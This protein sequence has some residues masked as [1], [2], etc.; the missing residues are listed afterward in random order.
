MRRGSPTRR[1]DVME[2]DHAGYQFLG[3]GDLLFA[4]TG[5][6]VRRRHGCRATRDPARTVQIKPEVRLRRIAAALS[7]RV[8]RL[9][10]KSSSAGVVPDTTPDRN[11]ASVALVV[12]PGETDL[13]LLLIKR[14][15]VASD[16]WSGHMALPGGRRSP[17]DSTS[18]DTAVRET[19][20]EVGIDLAS[21]GSLLGRL[22]D[23][24][25]RSGAPKIVVSP[26]VFA[27]PGAEGVHPN[28]EVALAVWIPLGHLADRGSATEYLHALSSGSLLR[29]PAI[30]YQEHVIWG[31]TH[32]IITQFLELVDF[33]S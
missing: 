4:A 19:L 27:V 22:D 5:V 18:I 6:N 1:L 15:T 23:V 12:R 30:S 29:F 24:Q 13:E 9:A 16:P 32:R 11:R 14:A 3:R 2:I 7:G 8:P 21:R 17:G 25:P 31:L 20:E 33:A 10:E 28:H 26:F